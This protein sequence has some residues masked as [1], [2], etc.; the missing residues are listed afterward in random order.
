[1]EDYIKMYRKIE[2]CLCIKD[3]IGTVEHNTDGTIFKKGDCYN[4]YQNINSIK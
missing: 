3:Y 2:E 1:M 4:C